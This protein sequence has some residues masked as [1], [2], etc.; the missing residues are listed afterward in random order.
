MTDIEAV[1]QRIKADYAALEKDYLAVCE[2]DSSLYNEFE[3]VTEE[4]DHW[5]A[6]AEK[7]EAELKEVRA[8]LNDALA[9]V[10][11]CHDMRREET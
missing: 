1:L 2:R 3:K 10:Q 7:A 8:L 6:R 5:K 11:D 4:R 9:A